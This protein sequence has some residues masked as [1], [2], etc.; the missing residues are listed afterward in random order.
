MD[1]YPR[2][3]DL[4]FGNGIECTLQGG[5]V[6][7]LVVV[8]VLLFVLP[9]VRRS[10]PSRGQ[11]P[12]RRRTSACRVRMLCLLIRYVQFRGVCG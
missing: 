9:R 7:V 1:I 12:I 11:I 10:Q 8:L 4:G 3:R 5:M 6:V 2:A